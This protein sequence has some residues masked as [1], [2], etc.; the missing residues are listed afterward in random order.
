MFTVL[1]NQFIDKLKKNVG[2]KM[3][4]SKIKCQTKDFFFISFYQVGIRDTGT[5]IGI[6]NGIR[7]VFDN[8]KFIEDFIKKSNSWAEANQIS[9]DR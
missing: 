1:I 8:L 9:E 7:A 3:I 5:V 6:F 2:L 4:F